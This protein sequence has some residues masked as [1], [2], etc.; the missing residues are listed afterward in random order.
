[1]LVLVGLLG[2]KHFVSVDAAFTD[3]CSSDSPSLLD[4]IGVELAEDL[5]LFFFR[6]P[7][8]LLYVF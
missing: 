1:M 6:S 4:L 2:R 8:Q 3:S 7:P 5:D